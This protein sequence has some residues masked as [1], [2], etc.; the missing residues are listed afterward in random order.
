MLIGTNAKWSIE[1]PRASFHDFSTLATTF[2][3]HFDLPIKH[4]TGTKLLTNFKQSYST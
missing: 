3:M 2:L 1:L 4:E